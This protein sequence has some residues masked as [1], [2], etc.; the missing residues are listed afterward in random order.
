VSGLRGLAVP[1]GSTTC[2]CVSVICGFGL[3]TELYHPKRHIR[4]HFNL[5]IKFSKQ[6]SMGNTIILYSLY[7]WDMHPLNST[8]PQR[9]S[10]FVTVFILSAVETASYF[11][12]SCCNTKYDKGQRRNT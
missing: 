7:I 3:R 8:Y 9:K 5:Q 10:P 12:A 11:L 6:E 4:E 2:V 1:E